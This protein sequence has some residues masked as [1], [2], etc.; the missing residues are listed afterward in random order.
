MKIV[1]YTAN[2]PVPFEQSYEL[3][4]DWNRVIFSNKTE[5]FDERT[6]KDLLANIELEHEK[7]I[8]Y[9]PQNREK[10]FKELLGNQFKKQLYLDKMTDKVSLKNMNLIGD[11]KLSQFFDKAMQ[12]VGIKTST[13]EYSPE[14][15]AL[16]DNII[17]AKNNQIDA[18]FILDFT[19]TNAYE[20]AV[21]TETGKILIKGLDKLTKSSQ[22]LKNISKMVNNF[23]HVVT[24]GQLNYGIFQFSKGILILYFIE[25]NE[26]L[27]IVGFISTKSDGIGRLLKHCKE[28]ISE[29]QKY[30]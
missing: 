11:N 8:F 6:V 29:I 17:K 14:L 19:Q 5:C 26:Q 21:N 2:D 16:L 13:K 9:V 28:Q 30:I 27:N 3:L 23:G 18:I 24:R 4:G 25:E 20:T 7:T 10:W 15:E 22:A 12:I 1:I